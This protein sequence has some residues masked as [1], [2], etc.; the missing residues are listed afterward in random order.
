MIRK[1]GGG[2]NSLD[3]C[4]LSVAVFRNFLREVLFRQGK[5][6]EIWAP[7]GRGGWEISKQ[8]SPGNLQD[9]EEDFAGEIDSAPVICAVKISVK[10]DERTVGVCYADASV[11]ELGVSEFADNDLYSNFEVC[12]PILSRTHLMAAS[13]WSYNLA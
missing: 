9:V 10:G 12:T 8:A 5:R 3:S 11:R 7:K 6:V 2:R 1:L 13:H 4:T